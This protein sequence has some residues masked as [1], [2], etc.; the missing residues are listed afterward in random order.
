M[1]DSIHKQKLKK[2][3]RRINNVLL[4]VS[5][6]LCIA[7]IALLLVDP[8]KNKM[9]KKAVNEGL[10]AIESQINSTDPN[11]E[12]TFVV[13]VN[14][15]EIEGEGYDYFGDDIEGTVNIEDELSASDGYATLNGIGIIDIESI[16]CRIPVWDEATVL[17][18]RYGAGH[19]PDSVMPGENGN[20]SILAH[21]MRETGSMFNRLDEV[22]YGDLVRLE[23][24]DGNVYT[25]EVDT[26]EIISAEELDARIAGSYYSDAR[27]TL[28]TC[29]Y[30][31]NGKMRLI[32]SGSLVDDQG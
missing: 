22:Q 31:A 19:Y 7:G 8:I 5:I 12:M 28:V 30:T 15:N 25:Y 16:E 20:C 29:T 23:M 1:R 21:H 32:V 9:R 3:R 18:L 2:K 24:V 4:I 17:S 14:G 27:I 10:S 6:V 26:I 11:V 13:P